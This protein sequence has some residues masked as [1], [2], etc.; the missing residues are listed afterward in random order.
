MADRGDWVIPTV[1]GR[2][3]AEKPILY[4]WCARLASGLL[5]EIDEFSLRVPSALS[6]ILSTILV[7][8]LVLPY[9]GHRRALL[10]AALF[11]TQ[12][13]VFWNARSVQMD[14][15]ILTSTLGVLVPL[16]RMLDFGAP[17][18]RSWMLAGLAAGLGFAAKGPVALIIP[19]IVFAAYAFSTRR[20]HWIGSRGFL[21]GAAVT[22]AV[23]APWYLLLWW[24]GNTSFL[25]EVL[26]R[27]N[28]GRFLAAWDHQRPWWYYL[29]YLWSDYAPWSW[30]LPAALLLRGG[31]A[32]EVRLRRL[33]WI[34]IAGVV[35][36]FSLSESKRSPY[37]LAIAPAIAVLAAMVVDRLASRRLERV[38]RFS[39]HGAMLAIGALMIA[40]AAFATTRGVAAYPDLASA[41]IGLAALLGVTGIAV[42]CGIVLSRRLPSLASGSLLTGIAAL[43]LVAAVWL[44]PSMDSRKSA[45]HFAEAVDQRLDEISGKVVSYRLWEWRAEYA[46]YAER[47]IP[48]LERPKELA[49]FWRNTRAPFV[50]VEGA[51]LGEVRETLPNSNILVHAR[52]GE[53]DAYLVG[54][55]S[56]SAAKGQTPMSGHVPSGR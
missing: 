23:A 53:R 46:Y 16:T 31:D 49:T 50:I 33:S 35:A 47:T 55:A 52:I 17:A 13:Q 22:V 37:I 56:L 15:L 44:L 54:K 4:Y 9:A 14:I 27:Q 12:Y 20:F 3:F 2:V 1:N 39:A 45:R 41:L 10:A 42:L 38:P 26:V 5:G 25:Y 43:Y 32:E 7:Y 24:R 48:G 29:G 19:G 30:L 34:W 8:L 6:G 36:F 11:A 18:G 51:H 21:A 28:F 40:A